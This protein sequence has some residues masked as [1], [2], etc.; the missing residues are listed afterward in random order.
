ME[1]RLENQ[2]GGAKQGENTDEERYRETR[3]NTG[4]NIRKAGKVLCEPGLREKGTRG[5]SRATGAAKSLQRPDRGKER[6]AIYRA[7]GKRQGQNQS[8][9]EREGDGGEGKSK[10]MG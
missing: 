4:R 1:T 10:K 7:G 8:P 5:Q 6:Q 2:G 3:E 9:R